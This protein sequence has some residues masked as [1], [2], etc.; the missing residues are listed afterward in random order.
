MASK[1]ELRCYAWASTIDDFTALS[2]SFGRKP[3]VRPK[4]T[5]LLVISILH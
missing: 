2:I 4:Q 3:G 1:Q 5:A